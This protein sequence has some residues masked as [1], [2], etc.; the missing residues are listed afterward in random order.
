[1]S[2]VQTTIRFPEELHRKLKKEA[3]EKGLTMNAFVINALWKETTTT[4]QKVG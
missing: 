2:M 3:K 4:E 1:M